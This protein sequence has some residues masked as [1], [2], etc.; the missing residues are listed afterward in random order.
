MGFEFSEE[1]VR[2]QVQGDGTG[3]AG[4]LR[5][6]AK[7]FVTFRMWAAQDGQKT[8]ERGY[9]AFRDAVYFSR[10]GEKNDGV[11]KEATEEHF[12]EYAAEYAQ[13]KE[14]MKDPQFPVYVLPYLAPHVLR[15][16]DAG[17]IT[18]VQELALAPNLTFRDNEGR[19]SQRVSIDAVPELKEPRRLAR[20][21]LG[22]RPEKPL[23][24]LPETETERL[25]R[26]LA[27]AQAKLSAAHP[28]QATA[29][30]KRGGRKPGSKNKPKAAAHVKD[31]ETDS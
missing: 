1:D 13:F 25:R 18:T 29:P 30:K 19:V 26:E 2:R 16:L 10:R 9:P 24:A 5:S 21:W 31:A 3:G 22:K 20:E 12:R 6:S 27:E 8:A 7:A 15:L 23:E 14:W 17:E 4:T 11:D 28:P